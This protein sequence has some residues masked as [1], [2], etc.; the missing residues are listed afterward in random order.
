MT[1][2]NNEWLKKFDSIRVFLGFGM[3]ISQIFSQAAGQKCRKVTIFV[4]TMSYNNK[5]YTDKVN[6]LSYTYKNKKAVYGNISSP[7]NRLL[8]HTH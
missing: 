8:N 6:T 4:N 1:F 5:I 3:N 2:K 7:L